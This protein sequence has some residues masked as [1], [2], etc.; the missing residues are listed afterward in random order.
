[1]INVL[2][3]ILGFRET[4]IRIFVHT[5]LQSRRIWGN[6]IQPYH[7]NTQDSTEER[8]ENRTRKVCIAQQTL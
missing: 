7:D 1:M 3:E 6:P 4:K 8:K 2:S 5:R